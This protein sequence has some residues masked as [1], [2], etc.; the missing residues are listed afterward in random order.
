[1]AMQC[2]C[3]LHL[4]FGA[5][6]PPNTRFFFIIFLLPGRLL[7]MHLRPP[8]LSH[9]PLFSC[10]VFKVNEDTTQVILGVRNWPIGIRNP[11]KIAPFFF[12]ACC[13]WVGQCQSMCRLYSSSYATP[14]VASVWQSEGRLGV[15]VLLCVCVCV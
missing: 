10:F 4:Q 2:H 1:M 5:I 9:R 11:A 8:S 14:M 15:L 13:T 6:D 7:C 12:G 3:G